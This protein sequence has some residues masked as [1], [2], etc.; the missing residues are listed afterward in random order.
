[1]RS[2]AG[3]Q[4]AASWRDPHQAETSM[5]LI[6][7]TGGQD[8]GPGRDRWR[9]VRSPGVPTSPASQTG[10]PRG[11]RISGP[12]GHENPARSPDPEDPAPD[13]VPELSVAGPYH[14]SDWPVEQTFCHVGPESGQLSA[15]IR[16]RVGFWGLWRAIPIGRTR[17]RG[18]NRGVE[19]TTDPAHGTPHRR[20]DPRCPE[21][22]ALPAP[23][24]S[25]TATIPRWSI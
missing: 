25:G 3:S 24:S 22:A 18:T 19:M 23:E 8:T 7:R 2:A 5:R 16:V 12:P 17:S 21:A 10:D 11:L 1:M 6:T 14:S 9:S 15:I 20:V 13:R 4:P